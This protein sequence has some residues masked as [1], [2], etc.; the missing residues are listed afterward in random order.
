MIQ[1]L[2]PKP[3]RPAR[4]VVLGSSGFLG[5]H[6]VA[7]LHD[8]GIKVLPLSSRDVNLCAA[9]AGESL[10]RLLHKDDA[11]VFASC[12]TPDKGKD[13]RT[14]MRNLAM[15]EQV[16]AALQAVPCAH[17]VYVSSD[18][19]YAD[20]E[21]L[22]REDSRCEPSSLY[23]L[24][25]LTRERMIRVTAE[26]SQTPWLIVRSTLVYGAGDTHNSYG[27]N[28]FAR[29]VQQAGVIKLFGN[30][31][32]KRDHIHVDD[33][34]RLLALCLQHRTSGILNL[35]TGTSTSFLEVAN[36]CLQYSRKSVTLEHLPRSGPVSHRHF[37]ISALARAFPAWTFTP[38]REG[39]ARD[40]FGD[41]AAAA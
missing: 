30:G 13:I 17:V 14:T 33:V 6:L 28:R 21:S 7:H 2:H 35:T 38:L 9:W 20:S 15:G 32:E 22:V 19:V 24:A 16:C 31:E 25:H 1:H 23:G 34:A 40:Y 12:L 41:V 11:L 18:A 3:V 5:R 10:A 36:L 26:A 8:Q 27:P 39:L 4:V 37:D 29:Q